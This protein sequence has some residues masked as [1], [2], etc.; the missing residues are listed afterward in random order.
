MNHDA[1]F[2]H[3]LYFLS[4]LDSL[5]SDLYMVSQYHFCFH[6]IVLAT[7][8]KK[9]T[10]QYIFLRIELD[11]PHSTTRSCIQRPSLL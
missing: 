10:S 1:Q 5:W 9:K 7:Q 4:S 11:R 3:N 2:A 8:L 6:P